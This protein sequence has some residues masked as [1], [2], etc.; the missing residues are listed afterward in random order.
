MVG[1]PYFGIAIWCI[2]PHT[3]EWDVPYQLAIPDFPVY[4][5]DA[6]RIGL[7]ILIR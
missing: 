6:Y 5:F 1:Y 2:P 7:G 3:T 4:S